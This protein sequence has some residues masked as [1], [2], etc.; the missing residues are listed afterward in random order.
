MQFVSASA[1]LAI[2]IVIRLRRRTEA[3]SRVDET[4]TVLTAVVFGVLI[5]ATSWG[6][7]ILQL[8]GT[9]SNATH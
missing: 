9:A 8:V 2:I 5:A 3:R 6:H 1:F 4:V 7:T